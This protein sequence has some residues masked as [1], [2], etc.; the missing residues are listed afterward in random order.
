MTCPAPQYTTT[1][2]NVLVWAG[3][4]QNAT[5]GCGNG[6][7]DG[8]IVPGGTTI[9]WNNAQMYSDFGVSP[10]PPPSG[11]SLTAGVL[12]GTANTAVQNAISAGASAIRGLQIPG[13]LTV[14]LN[15]T[16]GT[17]QL[18]GGSYTWNT[19]QPQVGK[20]TSI[21]VSA[22]TMPWGSFLANCCQGGNSPD[23]CSNYTQGGDSCPSLAT[24]AGCT[25]AASLANAS[26]QAPCLATP[27]SCD[28]IAQ[29]YCSGAG[30]GTPFCSCLNSTLQNPQCSDQTCISSGYKTAAMGQVMGSKC[31]TQCIQQSTTTGGSTSLFNTMNCGDAAKASN[32]TN[33]L[34]FVIVLCI[35][36]Y[37]LYSMYGGDQSQAGYVYPQPPQYYYGPANI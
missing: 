27:G 25:T 15:G 28:A 23:L 13:N 35:I 19:M 18:A 11:S 36:G 16:S 7:P 34:I 21:Q 12:W 17:V 3:L 31:P 29:Q 5:T 26:C 32:S 9:V 30:K 1:Q 14:T 8:Y 6:A 24:V 4:G 2:P 33:M 10:T 20:I 37:I 22:P